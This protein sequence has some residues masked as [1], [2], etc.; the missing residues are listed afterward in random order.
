LSKINYLKTTKADFIAEDNIIVGNVWL[1]G[2]VE[3]SCI[4]TEL[5]AVS[6]S[7]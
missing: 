1:S 3:G 4:I 5:Q 7:P 2:A 6:V